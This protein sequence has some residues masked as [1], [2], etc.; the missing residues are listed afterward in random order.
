MFYISLN[1]S[2]TNGRNSR[3]HLVSHS[4]ADQGLTWLFAFG[5]ETIRLKHATLLAKLPVNA[6]NT[7]W[8]AAWMKCKGAAFLQ[9]STNSDET[10]LRGLFAWSIAEPNRNILGQD[11]IH[12][13]RA[14][15]NGML[16]NNAMFLTARL[17]F[18]PVGMRSQLEGT[19]FWNVQQVTVS[20]AQKLC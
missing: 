13:K 14:P 5:C 2:K 4:L 17:A 11:M 3:T 19:Q 18:W 12:P 7:S 16:C 6:D 1:C 8:G 10:I 9:T 20:A 15:R